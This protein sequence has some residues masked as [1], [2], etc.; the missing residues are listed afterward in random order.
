MK[1]RKSERGTAEISVKRKNC[2][3]FVICLGS[4]VLVRKLNPI[5][6]VTNM[7]METD[8]SQ[9]CLF[10]DS[11]TSAEEGRKDCQRR[12]EATAK[13]SSKERKDKRNIVVIE[14]EKEKKKECV[15]RNKRGQE[16]GDV[17]R[18]KMRNIN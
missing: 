1:K 15:F 10:D 14:K 2:L 17:T 9:R 3:I 11:F 18:E 16:R 7:K 4:T 5:S 6:H 8:T 13:E 12:E